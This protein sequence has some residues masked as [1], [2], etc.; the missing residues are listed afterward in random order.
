MIHHTNTHTLTRVS[1]IKT[2]IWQKCCCA[3]VGR[4]NK[5]IW[6]A[7]I[8]P[9][10]TDGMTVPSCKRRR[11]QEVGDFH[12]KKKKEERGGMRP[13]NWDK[14]HS[15]R[16]SVSHGLGSA[17]GFHIP[18]RTIARVVSRKSLLL[19]IKKL[20]HSGGFSWK[21]TVRLTNPRAQLT[22]AQ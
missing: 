9:M 12:H 21:W 20:M 2:H 22:Q 10:E 4:G 16:R 18:R 5:T 3:R 19:T 6:H 8:T 15:G 14:T 11:T 13:K 17:V 7:T 1:K